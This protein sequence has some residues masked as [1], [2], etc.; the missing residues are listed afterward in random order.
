MK[1]SRRRVSVNILFEWFDTHQVCH[2][3]IYNNKLRVLLFSSIRESTDS[4][5]P[6]NQTNIT[7]WRSATSDLLNEN[8]SQVQNQIFHSKPYFLISKFGKN[9]NSTTSKFQL[10]WEKW[11]KG[12]RLGPIFDSNQPWVGNHLSLGLKLLFGDLILV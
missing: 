3:V 7:S 5:L 4:L 11:T 9:I 10:K 1:F 6:L 2:W 12:V 8:T